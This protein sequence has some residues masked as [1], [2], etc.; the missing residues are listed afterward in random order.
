MGL[1]AKG[2]TALRKIQ[3]GVSPGEVYYIDDTVA[4]TELLGYY[5][6]QALEDTVFTSITTKLAT[7]S[8]V[9]GGLAG[10]TLLVGHIWYLKI[11]GIELASGKV[12]MYKI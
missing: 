11:T 3:A 7:G 10:V 8:N 2:L 12:L 9:V 1:E 4:R 5:A 6:I